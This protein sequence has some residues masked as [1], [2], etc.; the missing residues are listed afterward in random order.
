MVI[1]LNLGSIGSTTWSEYLARFFF[2]GTITLL[3]GVIA[4]KFGPGIGGLF[5][6]FPAIFP[7]AATLIAKHQREEKR[8]WG[9]TGK[10]R[11]R[12]A[13]GVDAAGSA[14]GCIGLAGFA[15]AAWKLLPHLA[16]WMTLSLAT[17]FWAITAATVWIVCRRVRWIPG[18]FRSNRSSD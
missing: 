10:E 3:A 14:M 7:A 6:A 4:D 5:L 16:L 12:L 2:G 1:K 11:G 17:A 8:R 9:V 15:A 18:L 13:A